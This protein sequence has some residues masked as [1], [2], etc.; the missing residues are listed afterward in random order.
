MAAASLTKV[1]RNMALWTSPPERVEHVWTAYRNTDTRFRA[2][3]YGGRALPRQES[4]RWHEEGVGVAQ[5][6]AL[7]SNGAWAERCRY[8][9]IQD[10]VRRTEERRRL[11]Q[12]QVVEYD[13]ADLSTF[14]KYVACGLKPEWAVGDH[15]NTW[16]LARELQAAGYR[17]V[18][19]PAAAYDRPEAVNLTLWGERLENVIYG[20]MPDAAENPSP[21]VWIN[22]ILIA[23]GAAPPEHAMM[24]TSYINKHHRQF[25]RWCLANGYTP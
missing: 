21:D 10:D 20:E 11:W 8:A 3:W 4:G 23:D 16:P 9:N 25:D 17:G 14:D 18:L 7:S 22:A 12:L 1:A 19:S 13:V 5:Y 6:L 2:L 24:H 15:E